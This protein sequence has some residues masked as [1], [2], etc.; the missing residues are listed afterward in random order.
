MLSADNSP[1]AGAQQFEEHKC[2]Q[3]HGIASLEIVATTKLEKAKGPDL[4]GYSTEDVEALLE[5][6]RR[7]RS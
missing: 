3:C 1:Q 2:N 4:G 7:E 6:L 5:F